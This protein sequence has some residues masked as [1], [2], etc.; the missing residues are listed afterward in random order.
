M[1][2]SVPDTTDFSNRQTGATYTVSDR[3]KIEAVAVGGSHVIG[4]LRPS[5]V[6]MCTSKWND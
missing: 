4:Q 5:F 6:C 3:G 1:H 2:F